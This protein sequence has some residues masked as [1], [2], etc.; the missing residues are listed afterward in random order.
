M[1][2]SRK[3]PDSKS[4][5]YLLIQS[6]HVTVFQVY[7]SIEALD[8]F[9][10]SHCALLHCFLSLMTKAQSISVSSFRLYLSVLCIHLSVE[11]QW[12]ASA[13]GTHLP[14]L[15]HRSSADL[16]FIS[17]VALGWGSLAPDSYLS[18]E[19]ASQ[20]VRRRSRGRRLEAQSDMFEQLVWLTRYCWGSELQILGCFHF[21]GYLYFDSNCF[22]VIALLR[23]YRF[24]YLRLNDHFWFSVFASQYSFKMWHE[25]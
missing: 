19:A 16:L 15:T 9:F 5:V 2:F 13:E 11:P 24:I 17:C 18:P 14:S 3:G 10:V 1:T 6:C 20:Q 25:F 22:K 7:P 8:P 23:D 4:N 12:T 21:V